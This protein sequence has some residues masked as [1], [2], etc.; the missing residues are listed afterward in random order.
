MN[1]YL[2]VPFNIFTADSNYASRCPCIVTHYDPSC[3]LIYS[4]TNP[5]RNFVSKQDKTNELQTD[6]EQ[7]V[8]GFGGSPL[9]AGVTF[10][11]TKEILCD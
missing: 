3:I 6:A 5:T 1:L 4:V 9:F 8:S 2:P 10:Q 11:K 7:Y